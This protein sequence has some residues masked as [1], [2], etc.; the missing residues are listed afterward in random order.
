MGDQLELNTAPRTQHNIAF[1]ALRGCVPVEFPA[2]S[3]LTHPNFLTDSIA[4]VTVANDLYTQLIAFSE[5]VSVSL[6]EIL[7]VAVRILHLRYSGV[8]RAAIGT[9]FYCLHF[10]VHRAE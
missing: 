7:L 3:H 10:A 9:S 6:H 2:D 5:Q 8:V 1:D 4:S